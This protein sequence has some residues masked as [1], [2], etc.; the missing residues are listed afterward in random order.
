MPPPCCAPRPLW[1]P[2]AAEV[3]DE[4]AAGLGSDV[5]SQLDP[6]PSLAVGAGDVVRAVPE[7]DTHA[8]VVVPQP[9]ELSTADVY[10]EADRLGRHRGD[11]ELAGLKLELESFLA[12]SGS[13]L[14]P[15]LV[16]NDLAPA[17]LSLRPE[18]GAALEAVTERRC[19]AQPR[20]WFGTDRDRRLLGRCRV[21]QRGRR[22]RPAARPL[23]ARRRRPAGRERGRGADG[24]PVSVYRK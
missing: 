10:R 20:V 14:P 9:F 21:G 2:C 13:I 15:E 24:E 1:R 11:A 16:V 23:S 18:I 4:V 17:S 8:F 5:P 19:D 22:P 12:V 3:I 7:L 6:G